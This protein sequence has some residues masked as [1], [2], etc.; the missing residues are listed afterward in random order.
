MRHDL[1]E[2]FAVCLGERRTGKG[3]PGIDSGFKILP[4]LG[5][6]K[7]AARGMPQIEHEYNKKSE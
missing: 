5:S 4:D 6:E 7:P 3:T 1:V 2:T